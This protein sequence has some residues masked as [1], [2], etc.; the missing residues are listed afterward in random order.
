MIDFLDHILKER[1]STIAVLLLYCN[2]PSVMHVV[3]AV[4]VQV[5]YHPL[6]PRYGHP[7]PFTPITDGL[8]PITLTLLFERSCCRTRNISNIHVNIRGHLLYRCYL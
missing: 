5:L 8:H 4:Y 3:R 6:T 2:I 1:F 7:T